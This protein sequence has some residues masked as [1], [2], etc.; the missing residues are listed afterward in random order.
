MSAQKTKLKFDRLFSEFSIKNLHLKN[1]IVFLPHYTAYAEVTSLPSEEET[2]YYT[3]RAKGG[4]GLIITGNYAVSKVGQMHRTFINASDRRCITNFSKTVNNCHKYGAKI[5]GQLSHAGATKVELPR[6]SLYAPSQVLEKSTGSY[7]TAIA[8]DEIG[9]VVKEFGTAA[10]TLVMSGFDG[11]EVKVAH[12]GILRIFVSPYYNKRNDEYGGSFEN[13]MRII[14]EVFTEIRSKLTE[15]MVLGVRLSADEFE[16]DGFNLETGVQVAKYMADNKLVDYISCDAGTWNT[17]IMQIPPMTIPL[18][19]GEYI[20]AAIK[21]VVDI[22]VIAFGRINDPIQAEQILENG[23]AD[24]IGMARQLLC[25]PEWANKSKKGMVDDIRKCIGC[26]E[27]CIGQVFL[28]QPIKCIQNPAAG[29]EKK[30]GIG[31]LKKAEIKKKIVIAGGGVAGLKFA[32][33]SAKRGHEVVLFEKEKTLGGQINILKSIPFRNEYSE[34]VRY[35]EFILKEFPNVTIKAGVAANSEN[36]TSEKPDALLIAT[37]AV[38]Y[39]P[40]TVQNSKAVTSWDV[41][42]NKVDIGKSILVYDPL[43]HNEG[44]GIVEYLFDT[45][46]NINIRYITPQNDIC[47]NAKNENKDILLRKLLQEDLEIIPYYGLVSADDK[48]VSFNKAFTD[49]MMTIE[50]SSFD[51]FI[52]TG[53]L[54]SVDDL[55]WKFKEDGGVSE[56]YRLGDAKAPAD[57]EIA[58]HEA[59]ALARS[60]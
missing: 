43:S 23:S 40:D 14:H 48:A 2:Y 33:I 9:Q 47:A 31:T 18:G 7:T 27:G 30:L 22:P 28:M 19:F 25:D 5:I 20:A 4:T 10:E 59:E 35:L 60:I 54:K 15:N 57:V 58:I 8:K 11:V 46:K 50:D 17:F 34:V 41:L 29:K 6:A 42:E 39:I 36:I 51:N 3:E 56:V 44:V 21:K 12:D 26:E 37:G 24:L 49:K 1:R 38:S 45:Y 52:Y 53:S 16:D 13:K 32:E 55:Y